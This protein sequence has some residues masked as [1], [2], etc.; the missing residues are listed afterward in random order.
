M[1]MVQH[2]RRS[3]LRKLSQ[4]L[5]PVLPAMELPADEDGFGFNREARTS[6]A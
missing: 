3:I 2:W 5:F 6:K 4:H 1:A